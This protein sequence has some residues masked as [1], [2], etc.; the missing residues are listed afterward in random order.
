MDVEDSSFTLPQVRNPYAIPE[1]DEYALDTN[2]Y[3]GTP[4][5][6]AYQKAK[7]I[8]IVSGSHSEPAGGREGQ[9]RNITVM[10]PPYKAY[11]QNGAPLQNE[12]AAERDGSGNGYGE[13]RY[14]G[15]YSRGSGGYGQLGRI[16][17]ASTNS[18][19]EAK[20]EVF[21]SI[22][23][24]YAQPAQQHMT[25]AEE[26][27]GD[28]YEVGSREDYA[29]NAYRERQLTAEEEEEEDVI[30]TKQQIKFIK[31]Q[32]FASTENALRISS[33]AEE[34]GLAT[35][36]KLGVQSER[37]YNS[38]RNLDLAAAH[39][40]IG[41]DKAK[42]LKTISGSMFAVHVS[43]PFTSSQRAATRDADLINKHRKERAARE[44]T[45]T[46]GYGYKQRMESTFREL[47]SK[48]DRFGQ[49]NVSEK[50]LA[51][52]VIYQFEGDDEDEDLENKLSDNF[53]AL[54]NAARRLHIVAKA[55]G[56]EVKRQN[57]V[58]T[59]V[60]VKADQLDDGIVLNR[61]ILGRIH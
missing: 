42:E 39:T 15:P 13:D 17:S 44:E 24:R 5:S 38:E 23:D 48:G 18:T 10:P 21:G 22:R 61:A 31:R 29:S 6:S 1:E 54:A 52:R 58:L 55:T 34:S 20:D 16:A 53:D 35:L 7:M 36:T 28:C 19:E 9:N 4:T 49:N 57:E 8:N 47:G 51:E 30:A 25:T 41:K 26:Q 27:Q 59:R 11:S 33:Q 32:D 43:N 45:R 40:R 56:E 12:F 46:D 2:K 60:G 37:I 14:N 3:A 50:T